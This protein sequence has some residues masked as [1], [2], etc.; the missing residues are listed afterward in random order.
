[1]PEQLHVHSETAADIHSPVEKQGSNIRDP[2]TKEG[3]II[4]EQR[5]VQLKEKERVIS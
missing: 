5:H 1:M 4:P 3:H 2:Y